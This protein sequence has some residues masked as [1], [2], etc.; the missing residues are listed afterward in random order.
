MLLGERRRIISISVG[1]LLLVTLIVATALVLSQQASGSSFPEQESLSGEFWPPF[2]ATVHEVSASGEVSSALR[3]TTSTLTY[4]GRDQ[5]V[6]ATIEDSAEPSTAGIVRRISG[7]THIVSQPQFPDR[8]FSV[9][10]GELVIPGRWLALWD[11]V[12]EME[13]RTTD[14]GKI[15]LTYSELVDCSDLPECTAPPDTTVE[16]RRTVVVD[17][18]RIPVFVEET[19]GSRVLYRVTLEDL[20]TH[21]P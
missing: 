19:L 12:Q 2:D 3:A 7:N 8:V 15:E 5:W 13:R 4:K 1:T 18:S 6:L 20:R 14:D 21:T 10:P 9:A 16:F 17:E 11:T